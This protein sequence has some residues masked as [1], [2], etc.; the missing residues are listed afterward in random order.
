MFKNYR[1]Y[2]LI[3]DAYHYRRRERAL[4]LYG[5]FVDSGGLHTLSDDFSE[6]EE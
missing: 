5:G 6:D 2:Q 3:F 1:G 4:R